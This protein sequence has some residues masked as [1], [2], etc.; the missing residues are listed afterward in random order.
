MWR[1]PNFFKSVLTNVHKRNGFDYKKK[2][3]IGLKQNFEGKCS[4]NKEFI[5]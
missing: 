3:D 5:F 2:L 4:R 1:V